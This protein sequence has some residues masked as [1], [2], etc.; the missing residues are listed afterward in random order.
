[1]FDKMQNAYTSPSFCNN[2]TNQNIITAIRSFM[3]SGNCDL[4]W[5][6]AL[7]NDP[8]TVFYAVDDFDCSV[9]NMNVQVNAPDRTFSFK[10]ADLSFSYLTGESSDAE[11]R[12]VT[13]AVSGSGTFVFKSPSIIEVT[14]LRI[15]GRINTD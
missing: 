8:E 11:E 15:N 9:K 3:G 13:D 2:M 10:G 7:T 12:K 5:L 4:L 6:N 1:M 14:N